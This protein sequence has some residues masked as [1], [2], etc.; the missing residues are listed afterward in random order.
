MVTL[1]AFSGHYSVQYVMVVNAVITLLALAQV[2]ELARRE[3]GQ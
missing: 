1:A 3:V 2:R